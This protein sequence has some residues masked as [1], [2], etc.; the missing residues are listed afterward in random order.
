[1]NVGFKYGHR[2]CYIIYLWS[3]LNMQRE[4]TGNPLGENRISKL[5]RPYSDVR[6]I[7]D[8]DVS[9]TRGGARNRGG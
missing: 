2:V 8:R 9:V 4:L 7:G 3:W 6:R 5:V 1:M